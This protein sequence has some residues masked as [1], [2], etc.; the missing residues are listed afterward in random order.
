MGLAAQLPEIDEAGPV[1]EL[2]D[3]IDA[4]AQDAFDIIAG[5]SEIWF[6]L[7]DT[8]E[9][10][11]APKI[12][13]GMRDPLKMVQDNKKIA[14]DIKQALHEYADKLD[15]FKDRKRQLEIE[16]AAAEA[17]LA[18]AEAMPETKT[19]TD[20]EGNEREVPNDERDRAI[21]DAQKEL[22][23][24]ADEVKKL[25]DDVKDA[26]EELSWRIDNF[27]A[28]PPE[29]PQEAPED[30]A[31]N[32][33]SNGFFRFLQGAKDSLVDTGKALRDLGI[34]A[35]NGAKSAWKNRQKI[36]DTVKGLD[37]F[38]KNGGLGRMKD[39]SMRAMQDFDVKDAAS[40]AWRNTKN[41]ATNEWREFK[42]DPCLLYTSPSPRDS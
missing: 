6:K 20:S 38:V 22:D 9:A 4:T 7:T 35:Y 29:P 16:I 34:M 1:R 3:E 18:A 27:G 12:H 33:S 23:R 8:Y 30:G 32:R 24:L 31:E 17:D 14:Y 10:P 15:K 13:A 39:A 2:G 21:A 42:D 37:D 5:V 19:E 40:A 25:C 26:D 11:E 41:F 36:F 28:E